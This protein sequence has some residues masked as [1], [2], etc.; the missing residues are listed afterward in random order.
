MDPSTADI[1]PQEAPA[2]YTVISYPAHSMPDAYRNLVYSTWLRS[3]RFGNEY[4]KL[5]SSDAYYSNYDV[6]IK[7]LTNRPNSTLKLAV[8]SDNHDVVLGW[9][10]TEGTTLHYVHVQKDVRKN[11]IARSLMPA[12][13]NTITHLTTVGATIWASH[14]ISKPSDTSNKPV[15]IFNPFQ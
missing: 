14:C 8:L 3:L 5:I 9:S 10:L 11:G 6:Y 4:F 15:V 13:I 7:S 2:F 12:N 1:Q